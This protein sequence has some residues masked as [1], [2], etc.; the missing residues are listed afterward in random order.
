M[1]VGC[2]GVDEGELL[3][4]PVGRHEL[5]L[6][7]QLQSS[8]QRDGCS[9]LAAQPGTRLPPPK[10]QILN[11]C[12]CFPRNA[13]IVRIGNIPAPALVSLRPLIRSAVERS[14]PFKH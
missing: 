7:E 13:A 10:P 2:G 11:I 8:L 12:Q 3:M 5:N 9:I 14:S 4:C 6:P 1:R